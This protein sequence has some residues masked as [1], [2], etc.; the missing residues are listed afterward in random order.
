MEGI[1]HE[2]GT[3]RTSTRVSDGSSPWIR[4]SELD[5][6]E[7]RRTRRRRDLGALAEEKRGVDEGF[8]GREWRGSGLRVAVKLTG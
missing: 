7:Q 3:L 4:L 2:S 5:R 1:N 6:F 8:G